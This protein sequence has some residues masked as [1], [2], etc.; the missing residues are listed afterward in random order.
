MDTTKKCPYCAETIQVEA[1]VCRFCN[2]NLEVAPNPQHQNAKPKIMGFVFFLIA[3]WW[4]LGG[5]AMLMPNS[6]TQ[7]GSPFS[8]SIF[9]PASR[10][11]TYEVSGSA[12][13]ATLTYQNP[14][15]GTNQS[16]VRLPWQ[17]SLTFKDGDFAYISAQNKDASGS[18]T[19]QIFIDGVPWKKT[20]SSGGYTIADCNGSISKP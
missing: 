16:E 20:T 2:R 17:V 4:F 19:T 11:V 1:R 13:A 15:G 5:S 12:S 10:Q 3:C 7:R 9:A 8:S 14:Q 6:A 18:V